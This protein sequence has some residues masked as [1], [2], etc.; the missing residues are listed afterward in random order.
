MPWRPFRHSGSHK[1]VHLW[2]LHIGA[3]TNQQTDRPT[4]PTVSSPSS[5]A[6]TPSAKQILPHS[7]LQIPCTVDSRPTTCLRNAYCAEFRLV[8]RLPP[9]Y[10]Y[11]DPSHLYNSTKAFLHLKHL[12]KHV[13]CVQK[14]LILFF[15]STLVWFPDDGPLQTETQR[16]IKCDILM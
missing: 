9:R 11:H 3:I 8:R 10:C 13:S 5:E 7:I 1:N 14:W 15:C 2:P 16:N 12:L 6:N 4:N